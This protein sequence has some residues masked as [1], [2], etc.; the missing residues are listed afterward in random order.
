MAQGNL[1]GMLALGARAA[2]KKRIIYWQ[3]ATLKTRILNHIFFCTFVHTY[4]HQVFVL[5]INY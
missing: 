3:E 5:Q 1:E 2:A 4:R